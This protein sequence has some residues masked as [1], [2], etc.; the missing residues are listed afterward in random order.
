MEG[1]QPTTIPSEAREGSYPLADFLSSH[2]HKYDLDSRISHSCSLLLLSQRRAETQP[3]S[4]SQHTGNSDTP[5]KQ[6]YPCSCILCKRFLLFSA[7]PHTLVQPSHALHPQVT[8]P[9]LYILFF[10]CDIAN[11]N[12]AYYFDSNMLLL[13]QIRFITPQSHFG[14]R[15]LFS[16]REE[17][18]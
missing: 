14:K 1:E 11:D 4:G 7:C 9:R 3:L 2:L 10:L 12:R 17:E 18:S 15:G 6:F 5:S 16:W 8:F 13:L